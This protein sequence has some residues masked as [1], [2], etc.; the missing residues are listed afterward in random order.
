MFNL[1]K[2]DKILLLRI[3]RET[4]R[5]KIDG[6]E[7]NA[8]KYVDSL[9]NLNYKTGLFVTL[10][11]KA[12]L[13]GC[14]GRVDSNEYLHTAVRHI[15]ESAAFSDPRFP[16]LKSKELKDTV[17]E[18]SVLTPKIKV[19]NIKEIDINKHGI[20]IKNGH[21]SGTFLPQVALETGWDIEELLG[22]CA[23]DKVGIGWFDWKDSEIFIY[24]VIHFDELQMGLK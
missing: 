19:D 8:I 9:E 6:N 14:I 15:A 12:K 2:D 1:T 22:R 3:A 21:Q 4:L 16:P 18:I 7:N 24:E 13:R 11:R 20:Y 17:I 23:R 5:N 10:T